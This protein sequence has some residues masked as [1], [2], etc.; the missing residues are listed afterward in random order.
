M[1]RICVLHPWR[2]NSERRVAEVSTM[3]LQA[4][5]C[6]REHFPPAK[7]V[8]KM[9]FNVPVFSNL[10]SIGVIM[11]ERILPIQGVIT[12]YGYGIRLGV[13]RGHLV[14]EDGVGPSRRWGR[15]A[16]VGHGVRRVVVI[17]ADGCVSLPALRWLADQKAAF[18][19]LE[20]D[21]HVL[22]TTGPVHS[23][24]VRLRRLQAT[25]EETGSGLKLAARL[26][27]QKLFGQ[28]NVVREK[29]KNHIVADRI[30]VYASRL[31][32]IKRLD[33]LLSIEANAALEYWSAWSDLQIPYP[34]ADLCR[35]PDHWQVFGARISPITKSPRLAV[36]PPNAVLNYLYA[37]LEAEAR[38]A[39]AQLGLDPELGVLHKDTPNRD[40]L[41][42]DLMEPV[43]PL[44]DS[45]V[46][47]WLRRGPLRREWFFEEV[48][49]NCRLMASFASWLSE[50]ALTWRSAV[51]PYAEE[52]AEI[53]W[54]SRTKRSP[55]SY[56]PTRLTQSRRSQAKAGNLVGIAPIMPNA[57][58]RCPICGSPITTG[59]TYCAKCVPLV[60]RE[61]LLKQAQ[62]GRIATHSP[63][64]EARRAATQAS[65]ADALRKWNPSELP[66]WL[67]EAAYREE[68]LPRLANF[69]VK[70]IRTKLNVSHPYA[71]LIK[72]GNS[73]PH[74][75]HWIPLMNLTG[76]THSMS[77][78]SSV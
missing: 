45:F 14:M 26:I 64:A 73:I 24:D 49:G 5:K 32:S 42:C 43:R 29:L 39:A 6:T 70:A 62:L 57:K 76:Y 21:G 31:K 67:D 3:Q 13:D 54:R 69:T 51:A 78:N 68:I 59:S 15:F 28:E 50:T 19:M 72:R 40:S 38:L 65:Q 11:A 66:T 7:M 56:L 36:N 16:R 18:V 52:A 9:D 58:P 33:A 44:V 2:L 10:W 23:S 41:A 1:P 48:N 46:F 12:L 17:G 4:V 74:P 37:I 61:N 63:I 71:T 25:A 34:R 60:N 20:R 55:R 35:V 75:R 47:D 22:A 8:G 53:F 27:E 77:S 30:A